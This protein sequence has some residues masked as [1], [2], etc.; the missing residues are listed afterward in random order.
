MWALGILPTTMK[1]VTEYD[2]GDTVCIESNFAG[3]FPLAAMALGFIAMVTCISTIIDLWVTSPGAGGTAGNDEDEAGPPWPLGAARL[4]VN[5][6]AQPAADASPLI[7]A[8]AA[9]SKVLDDAPDDDADRACHYFVG[10]FSA[11]QV[12]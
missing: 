11:L 12:Q 3:M 5:T 2:F 4:S 10:T 6:T 7:K 8:A 1:D 9:D